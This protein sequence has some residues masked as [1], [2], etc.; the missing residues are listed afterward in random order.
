MRCHY[1]SDETE[2][3]SD[4]QAD[5]LMYAAIYVQIQYS[6]T[7]LFAIYNTFRHFH[8]LKITNALIWLFYI[9]T[10]CEVIARIIECT[11]AIMCPRDNMFNFDSTSA[12]WAVE[13]R[14]IAQCA[15]C[16]LDVLIVVTMQHISSS[17]KLMLNEID[18]KQ[19]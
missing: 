2:E 11:Y 1:S 16:A 14:S 18:I 12:S 9:F 4:Q 19:A 15:L 10:F 13:C 5:L 6:S 8:R 3:L 7:F 17:I